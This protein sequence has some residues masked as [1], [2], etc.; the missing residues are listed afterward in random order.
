VGIVQRIKKLTVIILCLAL[1]IVG[2]SNK[3]SSPLVTEVPQSVPRAENWGIYALDF[4]TEKVELIYSSTSK[5]GFL[6]LNE[7]GGTL[8]FSQQFAGSANENEEICTIGIDGGA[9]S[10]ITENSF[11]DTYPIWS[12]DGTRIA[13]LSW[14]DKDLDIYLMKNDGSEQ[15]KLYDSGG[16]DA[17]ID[18]VGNSIVFRESNM[19]DAG[20]RDGAGSHNSPAGCWNMG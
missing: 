18:W 2:C 7:A 14:R 15:R 8:T 12:P 10:R 4:T 11:F 5:I 1:G 6:A 20:R 9:F 19:A 3:G 16:H 17:D 13:F